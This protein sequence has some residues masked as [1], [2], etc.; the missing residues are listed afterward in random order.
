MK[1]RIT[2][3]LLVSIVLPLYSGS[4]V[5]AAVSPTDFDTLELGVLYT[6]ELVSDW[7]QVT[8]GATGKLTANVYQNDNGIFTYQLD[9]AA[10]SSTSP[11]E[12]NTQFSV[13]GFNGIAGYSFSDAIH[14]GS[15]DTSQ[16]FFIDHED[17]G[18]LDWN[19]NIYQM[20]E[21][22]WAAAEEIS[23]FFQSTL[24]P[25]EGGYNFISPASTATGYAPVPVP[26]AILL[27][28]S[29][30]LGL[31]AVRKKLNM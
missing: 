6:T 18:T 8:G 25:G 24:A 30:L 14:A 29:A 12:F 13:A 16:A 22:F 27:L 20:R 19:A 28:G 3:A 4:A 21:G 15:A 17:D 2:T 1:K 23:F 11:S 9:L 26:A 7:Q 31:T 10:A 5:S